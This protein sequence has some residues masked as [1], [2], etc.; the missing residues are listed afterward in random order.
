MDARTL[1]DL[2]SKGEGVSLEFKRCGNQP[3][4]DVFETVCSFAN[5]QGGDILL[6]VLDDGTIEG[7][8]PGRAA[9][10]QRNV[11]SVLSNPSCFNSAP[12]V[13]LEAIDAGGREVVR[14]WVPM[15]PVVYRWKGQVY[16]RVF[17][18]DVRVAGDEGVAAM[19]VRKSNQ[20]TERRVLPLMRPSDVRADLIEASRARIAARRPGHPWLSLSDE[21]LLRAAH[22]I[23]RDPSTGREGYNLACALLLGT[24]EAISDACPAYRTDVLAQARDTER[25]DD[26]L[27]VETNLVGS[28]DAITTWL[29]P[30]LPDPFRLEGTE[31][32]SPKSVIVRE[33]VCNCLMHREYSAPFPARV[34][35]GPD[36]LGTRNASRSMYS[37]RITPDNLSPTPKNP[38]IAGF[39]TQL[40][41]AEALGSGTR[42]LYRCSRLY[43]GKDP[44]LVDGDFFEALVPV[45]AGDLALTAGDVESVA[46]AMLSSRPA[47][48][49]A[50][51]AGACGVSA[52][53]ARRRLKALV[54]AGRLRESGSTRMLRYRLP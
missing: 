14:V 7:V 12:A 11:A 10:V 47:V 16:D 31:R 22:L 50:E 35:L 42:A 2:I 8:A 36:G 49:T 20:Y 29:E 18:A 37:V 44:L 1:R 38:I 13:E 51:V 23:G 46:M 45:P 6:G 17:D 19:Y 41:V 39:M 27:T 9:A 15:G 28:F 54:D 26:R 43:S 24:D 52:R 3:G 34:T 32:V 53:T 4:R 25:Y 48:T 40:G 21:G 30:R 5:R 33:L